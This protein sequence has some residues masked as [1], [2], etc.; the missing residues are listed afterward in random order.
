ME[1]GDSRTLLCDARD[2]AQAFAQESLAFRE[3][4]RTVCLEAHMEYRFVRTDTPPAE[5]LRAF[6][7]DRQQ[8]G[9]H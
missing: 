5:I 4:W 2:V 1:P 7:G 6:L 3:H 9:R 8:A